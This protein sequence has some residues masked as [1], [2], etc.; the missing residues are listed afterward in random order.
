M[1]QIYSVARLNQLVRNYYKL[2]GSGTD[3][4][5]ECKGRANGFVEA[6]L[7]TTKITK[8]QI[9]EII[10]KE[11]LEYFGTTRAKRLLATGNPHAT[12]VEKDWDRYDEPAYKRR[13]LRCKKK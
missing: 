2:S 9:D 4:A 13:P 5:H 7:L 1:A 6:L 11:H 12:L 10:E 3:K 8:K